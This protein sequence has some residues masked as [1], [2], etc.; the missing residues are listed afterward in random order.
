MPLQ[1]FIARALP[2]VS[3]AW[4]N[5]V[6]ALKFTV[7]GDAA[8][9]PAA[10]TALE[11]G[12]QLVSQGVDSGAANAAVV[13][14]NG[15]V[16]GF[17]RVVGCMVGFIGVT[18]NTGAATLNVNGTG[19]AAIQN[20]IGNP[21]TGGELSVNVIVMWTGA[22]WKIIAGAVTP[23]LARSA[24][25]TSSGVIPTNYLAPY[26][27]FINPER[28]G[29]AVAAIPATNAT[30]LSTAALIAVNSA[31][32][33][34]QV[35]AGIFRYSTKLTLLANVQLTGV[36]MG[37][38]AQ[39]ASVLSYTGTGG[40]GIQVDS[41]Y[42]RI[43]DISLWNEGTGAIGIFLNSTQTMLERVTVMP[44]NTFPGWSVAGI[45]NDTGA[46]TFTLLMRRCYIWGNNRGLDATRGNNITLDQCF[47]ESNNI[48]VLVGNTSNVS[49]MII[50]NGSVI[51]LFGTGHGAETDTS[52]SINVVA[53]SNFV[54]RDSYFEVNGGGVVGCT[55]Q[56]A[57]KLTTV[58]GAD[59]CANFLS[60]A[61]VNPA[62]IAIE[63]ANSAALAVEV[64]GGNKFA[65]FSVAGVGTSG[66]GSLTQ[67]MF[68]MNR[69]TDGTPFVYDNNF[70]P[71]ITFGGA[72]TGLTYG[73]RIG[74][75]Q[76]IENW[77]HFEIIIILTA[78]GSSAGVLRV[79]GLPA[80]SNNTTGNQPP[81]AIMASVLSTI[82]G[83]LMC[84][85]R[86]ND[87]KL[88]VFYLGTGTITE[89]TDANFNNTS[90]L[91][92]SGKYQLPLI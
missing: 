2:T 3:A 73:T 15:P 18:P 59:I 87:D 56:R 92:I 47:I 86:N 66:S 11:L 51:E 53:C 34:I 68:G 37:F 52:I 31:G 8:T 17:A 80:L 63:V 74:R 45:Q 72:A 57:I 55:T 71:G 1:N 85:V 42:V 70:I 41:S 58:D 75:Y 69:A 43:A 90:E 78:K 77:I 13:T 6:D 82:T 26:K 4:L 81:A 64:H 60:T 40:I 14:L 32:G 91:H 28:Y 84:L 33:V 16:T 50:S 48:N 67:L 39:S 65:G 35:P 38:A 22:A 24:V 83:A 49:N 62:T 20:Q 44:R 23:D 46:T 36:S 5:Q 61:L 12:P 88:Q 79:T 21:L 89:L 19:V 30:A 27:P 25:E 7:F 54:C 76:R 9:K 10:R 29:L